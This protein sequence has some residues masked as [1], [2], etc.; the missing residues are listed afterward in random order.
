M[1]LLPTLRRLPA[2]QPPRRLRGA[3]LL[4]DARLR[5]AYAL[6]M[7]KCHALKRAS[8]AKQRAGVSAPDG[9]FAMPGFACPA[10][11]MPDAA[12]QFR[13]H[14]FVAPECR[15]TSR[16]QTAR[17]LI[18]SPHVDFCLSD[19]HARHMVLLYRVLI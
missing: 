2:C 3:A 13:C 12:F 11:T 4:R 9:V 1:V 14:A 18:P 15:H 19:Y 7:L 5:L 10:P 16:E 17:L 8:A 6:L